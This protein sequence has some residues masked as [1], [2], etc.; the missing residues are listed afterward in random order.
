MDI[1]FDISFL[2]M[3]ILAG[4]SVL[5]TAWVQFTKE[6]FPDKIVKIWSI[7]SGLGI[8]YLSLCMVGCKFLWYHVLIYGIAAAVLGG[9]FYEIVKGTR[10]GM[11]SSDQMKN[12][13]GK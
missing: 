13:G 3:K 2:D 1:G 12:G 6:Y 4:I 8:A 11:R 5:L 9:L 10:V 7:G